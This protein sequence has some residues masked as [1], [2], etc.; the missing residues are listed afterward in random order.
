MIGDALGD[1]N[2][3]TANN[4]LFFPITPGNEDAS[5]ERLHN[6]GLTK[7][8]SGKYSGEYQKELL[9]ELEDKLN[10]ITGVVTNGLF[11]RRPADVLII[12]SDNKVIKK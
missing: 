10:Q 4:A 2:A 6:E 1:Y 3:A 11:A 8:F 12:A 9:D 7:F 5:W